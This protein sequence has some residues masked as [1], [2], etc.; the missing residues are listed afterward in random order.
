MGISRCAGWLRSRSHVGQG[1]PI[2][3]PSMPTTGRSHAEQP[4]ESGAL[5]STG[6]EAASR[7]AAL[8]VCECALSYANAY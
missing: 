8:R 6:D 4:Q 2:A 3:L 7:L 1:M 5:A